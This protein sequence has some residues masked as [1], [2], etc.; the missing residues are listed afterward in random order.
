MN[1]KLR[2]HDGTVT[3][4]VHKLVE[5]PPGSEP[6]VNRIN[7]DSVSTSNTAITRNELNTHLHIN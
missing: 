7:K 6:Q 3:V 4:E 2:L 1:R 5:I